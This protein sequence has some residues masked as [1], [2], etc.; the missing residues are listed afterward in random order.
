M[1]RTRTRRT[2]RMPASGRAMERMLKPA[3]IPNSAVAIT[4]LINPPVAAVDAPL[5]SDVAPWKVAAA[6][7]PAMIARTHFIR[8][9][10]W[11]MLDAAMR[12]PATTAAGAAIE[13]ITLSSQG[14]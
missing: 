14:I 10:I 5:A 12:V 11:T 1:R 3:A 7:P 2:T 13:S 4:G 9:L 6:P 8:G